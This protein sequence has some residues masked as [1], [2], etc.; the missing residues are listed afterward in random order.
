MDK[1]QIIDAMQANKEFSSQ[2]YQVA[3]TTHNPTYSG[4][5][6]YYR[7]D[8]LEVYV[9]TTYAADVRKVFALFNLWAKQ[10]GA[11]WIYDTEFKP[12]LFKVI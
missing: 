6:I 8:S 12:Y 10:H 11:K 5:S 3:Y 4:V 7:N 9:D 1:N 2:K